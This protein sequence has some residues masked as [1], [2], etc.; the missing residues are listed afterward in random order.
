MHFSRVAGDILYNLVKPEPAEVLAKLA[1]AKDIGEALD[2]YNPQQ[3]GYKA[4]KAKLAELRHGSVEAKTED[5]KPNPVHVA[6]GKTL[7]PGMSDPRVPALRKRLDVAGDKNSLH[8]DDA[9]AEAVKAFQTTADIG[10]DGML[11]PNTVRALER[12]ANGA[13]AFD[14]R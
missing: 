13:E 7:R 8:Y 11:G 9:V 12:R 3:P 2:S 10:V 6:E 5:K 1:G 4:L 14:G